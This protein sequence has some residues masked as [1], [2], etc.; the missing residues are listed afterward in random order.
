[1]R[2]RRAYCAGA[3]LIVGACGATALP[4]PVD[5]SDSPSVVRE[6]SLTR[7]PVALPEA[8]GLSGLDRDEGGAFWTVSE[9]TWHLVRFGGTR[10][11]EI[12]SV[13]PVDEMAD[14]EGVVSLGGER[15]ALSTESTAER[16]H[17]D[18]LIVEL[19]GSQAP[20]RHRLRANYEGLEGGGPGSNRG[21][22]GICAAG[23]WIVAAAE[24]SWSDDQGRLSRVFAWRSE[25][26]EETALGGE[27]AMQDATFALRLT[28]DEGK[29]S[30]LTCEQVSDGTLRVWAIE[31]HYTVM[32]IISFLLQLQTH[33]QTDPV[34]VPSL[35]WE[36]AGR[37]E[38]DPNL[39]GLACEGS[40]FWM[41]TD[42]W[43]GE[44]M[45]EHEL[46]RLQP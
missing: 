15:F 25:A 37:L 27:P 14:L 11:S 31:R 41:I 6:L 4:A 28:T 13:L 29:I 3:F 39:E 24:Q 44:Q 16:M 2:L 42:N 35:Q 7:I 5:R 33:E 38:G 26:A 36:L 45:G 34:L 19:E 22:E 8:R 21:L 43:Y 10:P 18:V 1:M 46:I 40:T 12:F 30:A 20:V 17:D 23:G 32:R 9:S